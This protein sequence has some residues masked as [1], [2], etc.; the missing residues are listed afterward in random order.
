MHAI[1]PSFYLG[2][3]GRLALIL[4]LVSVLAFTLVS[5]SPVDPVS[6]YIGIDR[7]QISVEQ[8]QRIIERWGL[9]KPA[10][11]RFVIWAGRVLRG[12]LG[13]SMI[14]NEPVT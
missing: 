1:S 3:L 5:L 7:M 11:E 2:K 8:E 10:P 6:A 9:D 13:Q 14:F 4:S 12:D